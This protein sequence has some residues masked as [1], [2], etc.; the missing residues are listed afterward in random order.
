MM[1]N[2]E[3]HNYL[4]MLRH[5]LEQGEK[6]QDRTGIGTLSVFGTQLRFSLEDN[7][8]PMLTTKKMFARGVIE[9]LL[10][11]LRGDTDTKKLEAKGVNIWKGNT[12][13]EFQ[14]KQGLVWLREGEMGKGYGWEWRR[15]GTEL[16]SVD[17]VKEVLISL[18]E[19]PYG[20]RHIITAWNPCDLRATVLPPC[21]TFYQFYVSDGKLSCQ[22]YMRSVDTF[23]GLPFNILSY[24]CLTRIIAQTVGLGTKELVF[25]GGDTHLYFNHIEQVKEQLGREPYEF[26]KMTIG[27]ATSS[28]EDIEALQFEDFEITGYKSH[29]TIKAEMAI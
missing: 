12:S 15:F 8:V 22:F 20:R 3:E 2:K 13:R 29:P 11:F 27:R 9:E 25:T 17:Q 5:I 21:H 19:N 7:V 6:R 26:P 28:I 14:E 4:D 24:A 18:K 23:L 1:Q 16:H 10:F